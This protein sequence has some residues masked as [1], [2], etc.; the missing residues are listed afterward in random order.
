MSIICDILLLFTLFNLK[1]TF[2]ILQR[3]LVFNIRISSLLRLVSIIFHILSHINQAYLLLIWQHWRWGW[4]RKLILDL[5]SKFI[6]IY[7]ILISL[8]A[9]NMSIQN[10]FTLKCFKAGLV[11]ARVGPT[12]SMN[13]KMP[14]HFGSIS[15]TFPTVQ[16]LT[17]K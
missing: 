13:S 11:W 5:R 3:N 12:I 2:N 4:N 7:L 1:A 9:F 17:N 10:I 6:M 16:M 14:F 15:K 8:M